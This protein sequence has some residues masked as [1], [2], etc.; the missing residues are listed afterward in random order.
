MF[1]TMMVTFREG[2]EAFLIVAITALYL[3]NTGR[4]ALLKAVRLGTGLAIAGSIILGV[5]LA[6][7]GA[8]SPLWEGALALLAMFLVLSCT[9]H[10]M[11]HGKRM[12]QHIREHV[13]AN[14]AA[15]T[16]GAFV[17]VFLFTVLMIGREGIETATML[18]ALSS[19][20]SMRQF[21]WG[22]IGGVALAALLAFAWLRYGRRVN[23]GRFFQITAVFMVLFSLQ[24]G[25]YAFHEFS[26]AHALP[27]VD[28]EYWHNATEPYGPE[29]E[30][31]A[32]ISYSL[33]L[34][35]LALLAFAWWKDR[36]HAIPTA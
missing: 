7:V 27:L 17:G 3:R 34:V 8:M 31:G 36:P 5:V 1:Q 10:I 23:L 30:I 21:L 9:V 16:K 12:A 26:E 19:Q 2:V 11:R 22:G 15:G 32:W 13:D 24:L 20:A 35:P 33:V 6:R 29:G 28:N 4:V 18:A 14:A 25:I